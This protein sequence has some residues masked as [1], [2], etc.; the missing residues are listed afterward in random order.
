MKNYIIILFLI[1][2]CEPLVPQQSDNEKKLVFDD[3]NYKNNVGLA[4]LLTKNNSHFNLFENPIIELNKSNTIW[5]SFDIH[6]QQVEALNARIIHCDKNWIP[7]P[8]S[9]MEF[10]QG[11]ND[12]RINT[13]NNSINTLPPYIHYQLEIPKPK[14]S[15]NYILVVYKRS[16]RND[17]IL[18][19][20]FLVYENLTNINHKFKISDI[21]AKRRENHQINF[22]INY[23]K[24]QSNNP[25]EDL[26]VVILQNHSWKNAIK[27]LKP[28]LTRINEN[29]LEY[30]HWDGENNFSGLHE[31][32][33]I[34]LR[35]SRVAGRNVRSITQEN[36][37]ILMT[38]RTDLPRGHQTY[39]RNIR[40]DINGN[41][42]I[43]NLNVGE[44]HL[45][46]NYITALFSLKSEKIRG[47]VYVAGRFNN[48]KMENENKMTYDSAKEM[49]T[50]SI[51][52]KQGYYEY[53][54]YVTH[55]DLPFYFFE[56]S[57]SLTEN[58]YEILLYYRKQGNFYDQLV[59]YSAFKSTVQ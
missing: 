10:T 17:L 13:Y 48:W 22:D 57:H 37:Q 56:G 52:L 29:R 33:F 35:T 32:R 47:N 14:I 6:S 21:V 5:L 49:Y 54:Y 12:Y 39:S 53:L 4:R 15:G 8:I 28:T 41:F 59:G 24:L 51:T 45:Y 19:R 50:A 1:I 36:N 16:N 26:Y 7:T 20:K 9:S 38:L 31:F 46:A 27:G 44:T 43:E 11:I 34:D 55:S 23:R 58:E 42:R 18:S 3:V 2:A 40:K 25:L 30:K